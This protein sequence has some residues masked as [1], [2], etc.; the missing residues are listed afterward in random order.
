MTH[1]SIPER[2]RWGAHR[3]LKR[4]PSYDDAEVHA[5]RSP[6]AGAESLGSVLGTYANAESAVIIFEN[7]LEV[8][9]GGGVEYFSYDSMAGVEIGTSRK[10]EQA[11]GVELLLRSGRRVSIPVD[12][13]V[14]RQRDAW[15]MLRFLRRV[16]VE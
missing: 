5:A 15:E 12:G 4:L 1:T 16:L 7:G 13:G 3:I 9:S 14:G 11:T 2:A 6:R 10:K 8:R